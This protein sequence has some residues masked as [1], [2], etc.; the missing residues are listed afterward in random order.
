M[1]KK[2]IFLWPWNFKKSDWYRYEIDKLNS[3]K[4]SSLEVHQLANI[5]SYK[6]QIKNNLKKNKSIK[7]F[8]NL[9]TWVKKIKNLSKKEK[10]F[11]INEIKPFNYATFKVRKILKSLQKNNQIYLIEYY[12]NECPAPEKQGLKFIKEIFFQL[13]FNPYLFFSSLRTKFFNL[14]DSKI[15]LYPNYLLLTNNQKPL[16]NLVSKKIKVSSL[17][18]SNYLITKNLRATKKKYGIYIDSPLPG[19]SDNNFF[20]YNFPFKSENWFK[21]L[22]LF[23]LKIENVFNLKILIAPHPKNNLNYLKKIYKNRKIL[24]GPISQYSKSADLFISRNSTAL[25]FPVIHK[26][27]IF[28]VYSDDQKNISNYID[29]LHY[30]AFSKE[31]NIKPINIDREYTKSFI[32]KSFKIDKSSFLTYEKKFLTS[33][34]LTEPNY[35]V[36]KKFIFLNN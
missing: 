25:S 16:N 10:I 7:I 21:S 29:V 24:K 3:F 27:P 26:K 18:F 28:L 22:N 8:D 34:N 6:R 13:L 15:K 14:L 5:I 12:G 30:K 17:D 32:K 36:I 35:K 33:K 2:I 11:I 20:Y 4:G 23:F 31:L 9:N 19:S 1:K